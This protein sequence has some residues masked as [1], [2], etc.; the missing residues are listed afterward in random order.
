MAQFLVREGNVVFQGQAIQNFHRTHHIV[1]CTQGH[2]ALFQLAPVFS[3]DVGTAIVACNNE[4]LADGK[5]GGQFLLVGHF[6]IDVLTQNQPIGAVQLHIEGISAGIA[7]FIGAAAHHHAVVIVI[8]LAG[9]FVVHQG[10]R[11]HPGLAG[12]GAGDDLHPGALGDAPPLQFSQGALNAI[13][14]CL[15]NTDIGQGVAVVVRSAF[16]HGLHPSVDR[17]YH[18]GMLQNVLGPG[19]FPFLGLEVQFRFLQIH[20]GGL[21]LNGVLQLVGAPH[22]ALLPL[23]ILDLALVIFNGSRKLIPLQLLL[24]QSQLQ[25]LG[26]VGEQGLS[27]LHIVAFLHQQLRHGLFAVL[28]DLRHVFRHHQAAETVTGSNAPHPCQRSH[29]LDVY[30]SILPAAASQGQC[31][32]QRQTEDLSSFHNPSS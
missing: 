22:P 6:Q 21:N 10:H 18:R 23:Q 7:H 4:G 2:A 17:G 19:N 27:F 26:V 32:H 8:A 5:S 24:F 25:F 31:Q 14:A 16:F 15:L 20:L 28:L 3:P 12:I 1:H 30:L 29:G 11:A 13:G 9:V